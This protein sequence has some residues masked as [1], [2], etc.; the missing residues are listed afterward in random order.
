LDDVA[1]IGARYRGVT[2]GSLTGSR[3]A[4]R[5]LPGVSASILRLPADVGDALLVA[6]LAL[7]LEVQI[8]VTRPPGSLALNLVSGIALSVSLFWRRRAPLAMLA[9]FAATAIANEALGGALFT[10]TDPG[11]S[12]ANPPLYG[13]LATGIAVFYSIG[14]YAEDRRARIGLLAGIA[15]LWIMAIAADHTRLE[16]FVWSAGLLAATPWF[17]GRAARGRRL[18]I[19][20]LEREREQ[21]ARIAVG[22]ERARIARELHDIIAHSVSVI[23]VQAQGARSVLDRDPEQAVEALEAIER[24]AQSALGDMRHSLA[25]LRKGRSETPL[26]PQPTVD[27]LDA[28]VAQARASGLQVELAIEGERRPLPHSLEL[29]AYRIVQE[30]L[31]NTIK[32]AGGARSRVAI[33]YGKRELEIAVDD[34]GPGPPA[35]PRNDQPGHGLI[36]MRERAAALGGE[37]LTGARSGGGFVVHA[38]LPLSR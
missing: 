23:A 21:Q 27:D 19:A 8:V 25:A 28:L 31:T 5:W 13:A 11:Q 29:S 37:L 30:A 34:D 18:R 38:T 10:S 36:G 7:A 33:R 9:A 2:M 6:V 20:A 15:C 17:A 14:E 35:G 12:S 22:D 4:N 26:R 32:H 3:A 16:T 24:T 1:A